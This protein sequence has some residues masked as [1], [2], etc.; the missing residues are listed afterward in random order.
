MSTLLTDE[1]K[2]LCYKSLTSY[3]AYRALSLSSIIRTLKLNPYN[4]LFVKDAEITLKNQNVISID[5]IDKKGL[6]A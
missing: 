1:E 4:I 2:D 3:E 6:D 5:Y